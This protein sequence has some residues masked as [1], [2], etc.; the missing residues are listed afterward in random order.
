MELGPFLVQ[1]IMRRK[2]LMF[3]CVCVHISC[4][5]SLNS[6]CNYSCVTVSTYGLTSQV[7][8]KPEIVSSYRTN[9][10][11][12]YT[13]HNQ[14]LHDCDDVT[15]TKLAYNWDFLR[16]FCSSTHLKTKVHFGDRIATH[17]QANN[18]Y[19]TYFS[20]RR[21]AILSPKRP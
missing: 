10:I 18:Q 13:L 14:L 11:K 19:D 9:F 3:F 8:W 12:L 16:G 15:Y 1:R 20:L 2:W 21:G 6:I 17:P 5:R 7:Q 4:I